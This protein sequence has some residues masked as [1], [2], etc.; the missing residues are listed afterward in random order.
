MK[1]KTELPASPHWQ[2]VFSADNVEHRRLT[3]ANPIVSFPTSKSALHLVRPRSPLM[4]DLLIHLDTDPTIVL[5]AAFP[6]E[7]EYWTVATNGEPTL[8]THVPD[9][10]V[11]R[12]DGRIVVIDVVPRDEME[13]N[14][15]RIEQRTDDLKAHYLGFEAEY[16]VLSEAE[17]YQ[18]PKFDNRRDMWQ[19]KAFDG[20]DPAI[21]QI[22]LAILSQPLPMRLGDLARRLTAPCPRE[23]WLDGSGPLYSAAKQLVMS[24]EVEVDLTTPF[25]LFTVIQFP[26]HSTRRWNRTRDRRR[27]PR[28]SDSHVRTRT[29]RTTGIDETRCSSNPNPS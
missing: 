28:Q 9:V 5:I 18:Q 8:R 29:Y 2:Q 11:F 1:L 14:R 7:V 23:E 12:R 3:P 25:S 20:Q 15:A 13:S 6:E 27:L 24:G 17:I 19:H 10:A 26:P 16:I 21:G 4:R 22:A